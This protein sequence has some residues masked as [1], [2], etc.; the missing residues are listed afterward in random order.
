MLR[1]L[2]GTMPETGSTWR[3]RD[4]SSP[5]TNE[6]IVKVVEVRENWVKFHNLKD[7]PSNAYSLPVRLFREN[8]RELKNG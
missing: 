3:D 1:W 2:L 7:T 8:Y 4:R 5:F 6:G